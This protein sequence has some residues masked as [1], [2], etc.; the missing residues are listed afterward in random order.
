MRVLL[1]GSAR[2]VHVNL[3][4]GCLFCCKPLQDSNMLIYPRGES[5]KALAIT[6]KLQPTA[7]QAHV[8]LSEGSI[9]QVFEDHREAAKSCMLRSC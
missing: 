3:S 2:Q 4:E 1:Q 6:G 7:N 5:R 9:P 8:N